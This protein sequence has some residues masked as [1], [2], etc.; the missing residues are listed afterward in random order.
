MK[1]CPLCN[2]KSRIHVSLNHIFNDSY[3]LC[4][5]CFSNFKV[6]YQRF[7]IEGCNCLAIYDY[8]SIKDHLF[9]LKGLY[10]IALAPIFLERFKFYLRLE[11][12]G[13]ALASV[14]SNID[15]DVK[16][17]FNHVS[18]IFKILNLNSKK[19]FYKNRHYKQSDQSYADRVKIKDI[20]MI[21]KRVKIPDKVLIIDD[22]LTSGNTVK[23]CINLVKKGGAK[24][25]KVL[26]L[27]IVCR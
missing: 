12:E 14:P 18:E 16:R 20:I 4:D 2:T 11:F 24:R 7:K 25:V 15:E 17:G 22:V 26:V 6:I 27:S 10:D 3:L 19:L 5:Y 9:R 21:N 1:M 23:T 13:Y 8:Q